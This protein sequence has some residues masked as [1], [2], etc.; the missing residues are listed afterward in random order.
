MKPIKL[1]FFER[2]NYQYGSKLVILSMVASV[3]KVSQRYAKE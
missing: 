3:L 2:L 1:P